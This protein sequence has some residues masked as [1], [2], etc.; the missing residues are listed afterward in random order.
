M[1]RKHEL[2]TLFMLSLF[3][4]SLLMGP[5][6]INQHDSLDSQSNMV[7]APPR[8]PYKLADSLPPNYTHVEWDQGTTSESWNDTSSWSNWEFGP[9]ITWSVSNATTGQVITLN[10]TIGINGWTNF[11]LK[12]PKNAIGGKIP[13]AVIITGTYVNFTEVAAKMSGAPYEPAPYTTS[14]LGVF[15]VSTGLWQIY[16]SKNATF[17]RGSDSGPPSGPSMEASVSPSLPPGWTL[18]DMFG[19]ELDPFL[20]INTAGCGYFPGPQNIW[21]QFQLR[22]NSSTEL[23]LYRIHALAVDSSL[24]PIAESHEDD[25][26]VRAI[27]ITF[28]QALQAVVGGYYS[29]SRVD[30]DGNILYSATRGED[31][32]TTY[33]IS[34]SYLDNATLL[35]GLPN[36]IHVQRLIES[37]YIRVVNRTGGWQYDSTLD[38]YFWNASINVRA[39]EQVWGLH[40]ETVDEWLDPTVEYQHIDPQSG[41]TVT[42]FAEL[43]IAVV[44]WFTNDSFSYL[45]H[46]EEMHFVDDSMGGHLEPTQ[47]FEPFPSDGSIPETYVLNASASGYSTDGVHDIITFR[48]H[49]SEDALPTG[50]DVAP[51]QVQTLVMDLFGRTLIPYAWMPFASTE[52]AAAYDRFRELAIDSPIAVVRL[53]H[54]NKPYD[55]SWMF[56]TQRAETFTVKSRLQGGAAYANDIDG[57]ALV[58]RG[59]EYQ[60]SDE[61]PNSWSQD[62]QVEIWMKI[63]PDGYKDVTV[64]N[65]THRVEYVY[66]DSYQWQYIETFPGHW[67]WQYIP[68]T[69]WY[70]QEFFW[71][72]EANDWTTEPLMYQSNKTVMPISYVNIGNLTYNVLG[73]D[74]SITFDVTPTVQMPEMEWQ[75]DYYYGNLTWVKD[76]EAG[77]GEHVVLDWTD[78]LVHSYEN[79]SRVYIT[80]PRR[81]VVMRDNDTDSLLDTKTMPYIV[82]G[83]EKLYV[84]RFTET[85]IDGNERQFI[86]FKEWNATA[87]NEASNQYDGDWEYYYRLTNGTRIY[88]YQGR[89]VPIYNITTPFDSFLAVENVTHPHINPVYEYMFAINGSP[90]VDFSSIWASSTNV[91]LDYIDLTKVGLASVV[92]D[93]KTLFMATYPEWVGDHYV[94]YENATWQRFDVWWGYCPEYNREAYYYVNG[95]STY[96][97]FKGIWPQDVFEGWYKGTKVLALSDTVE[98]FMYTDILGPKMWL[99]EPSKSTHDF[100]ELEHNTPSDIMVR[101]EGQ[102]VNVTYVGTYTHPTDGYNYDFYHAIVNGT[103]Y[104][105]TKFS[106]SPDTWQP[107]GDSDNPLTSIANGSLFIRNLQFNGWT[108]TYGHR[109]NVTWEF[110]P[111]GQIEVTTGSPPDEEDSGEI[112]NYGANGSQY[113]VT[114]DGFVMNYTRPDRG[115]FYNVTLSNGTFFYTAMPYPY[116]YT[117]FNE[118]RGSYDLIYW[119]TWDLNGSKVTWVDTDVSSVT[120][121]IADV[122]NST[123]E[124]FLFDGTWYNHTDYAVS[125]WNFENQ[126][127]ES[128]NYNNMVVDYDY[129]VLTN[130]TVSLEIYDLCIDKGN[131]FNMPRYN[132][133]LDGGV[134]YWNVTSSHEMI[135]KAHNVWGYPLKYDYAALPIT[136]MRDQYSLVV[137]NPEFGLWDVQSWSI[138]PATGALDLDGN[139]TTTDDQF[140]VK[141]VHESTDFYNVTEQYLQV[142]IEWEPDN[143]TVGDEFY[144]DSYTGLVTVNWSYFWADN[145][146]WYNA[147]S[148]DLLSPSE[149]N[150]YVN[151]TI[152]DPSGAPRPGYWG[153]SWMA[154]NFTSNDLK[155]KAID[156]GWD[157]AIE[158]TQEWSWVWWQLSEHYGSEMSNGT[159][160]SVDVWYE[161]A[162]MFAW[163]DTNSNDIMDFNSVDLANSEATHYWLPT[164][165]G[166]V[167]FT[168]PNGSL[169]GD[170]YWDVN[171]TVPFGVTFENVS[172]TAFPFGGNSYWDWYTGSQT[173][174]FMTFEER[175][176]QVNVT[177][178][179]IGAAFSGHINTG[180][181][182]NNGTV[183]FNL[184]VG[185]WD[186]D[187]PGGKSV[188]D[189]LSLGMAFYTDVLMVSE[190]GTILDASYFD[191]S[192]QPVSNNQ[193]VGSSNFSL[194]VG[195][196]SIA[197]MNLGGAYYSWARNKSANYTIVDS[198]TVPVDAFEAAYASQGGTTVTPF[199]ISTS[200]F[201]TLID[202]KWW[203]GYAVTVDPVFV[204]YSSANGVTDMIAPQ[205]QSMTNSTRFVDNK[206][207][208][209]V[210]VDATDTGGS[211]IREV[212]L[213]NLDDLNANTTL[214]FDSGTKQWT[215]YVEMV[216]TTPYTFNGKIEVYDYAGN[217]NSTSSF[218]HK[219]WNDPDAPSIASLGLAS[220]SGKVYAHITADVSDIGVSGIAYVEVYILNT[221]QTVRMEY[222]ATLDLYEAYVTRASNFAYTLYY[223]VRAY[224]NARNLVSSS[225]QSYRFIDAQPPVI[226]SVTGSKGEVSGDEVLIVD[227][228]IIDEGGSG[229]AS[230]QLTYTIGGHPTTVDMTY[231]SSSQLYTYTVPNQAPGTYV[232]YTVSATDNDGNTATSDEQ[233]YRFSSEGDTPP[234]MGAL[235]I[236]PTSPTSS[237]SVNVS[238][239]VLDDGTIENVTLYYRVNA[240]SWNNLSM[241]ANG[242]TYWALIP[243]QP[244]GSNVSYYVVAFDNLGQS[245]QSD[246]FYYV[247]FDDLSPPSISVSVDKAHPTSNDSVTVTAVV[248]DD[249]GIQNVTLYYKVGDGSWNMVSMTNVSASQYQG[250]IPAQSDGSVVTYY[251]RAYD[252]SGKYTDSPQLSY[253]VQDATETTTTTLPTT[254]STT[255]LPGEL[256]PMILIAIGGGVAVV[257]VIVIVLR[258]RKVK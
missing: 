3:T 236:T 35:F 19:P 233:V 234:G 212:R 87:F 230:V 224:D 147:T 195:T 136:I 228:S 114:V 197:S 170:A 41:D 49:I 152:F 52:E 145:Y 2:V 92:N 203:D 18:Q 78:S 204:S 100:Y 15:E 221:E 12:I 103:T 46:H 1:I 186:I 180:G 110:I 83:G 135:Y 258:L 142:S 250:I 25:T 37:D 79:G 63:S 27:G 23:G 223:I 102:W 211:G 227:A 158:D 39:T 80:T 66:G 216:G 14:F 29:V 214:T 139:Y 247:V 118:S 26:S 162:G 248:T 22:F 48:G 202:F 21:T 44:Y 169:S 73:N 10:D 157:W 243:A 51:L 133:T 104:N 95:S 210:S 257:V 116:D 184:T 196:D 209:Y 88:A 244:D 179:G 153:I 134:T 72:F 200:Q 128:W 61:G 252:L 105:L 160:M 32:N 113:V 127:W 57:V 38:T 75:W 181:G 140:Y 124:Q 168:T 8:M 76:Y 77:W 86:L 107:Y 91:L 201:Y 85:D 108:V 185:D 47:V 206:E 58:L 222:N 68:V 121:I 74:L 249:T 96:W 150:T 187:A 171:T 11:L 218:Q 70:W 253:T 229:L 30:D 130:G 213:V 34:G 7:S 165:F 97:F 155:Q 109:D 129:V 251:V 245:T 246:I 81:S 111:D 9:T 189:G 240:G 167:V 225:T 237:D 174:D 5:P 69:G 146:Y 176:T 99:P 161:Y 194:G 24:V 192:G 65:M 232:F 94:I 112:Q 149:F 193:T 239:T 241:T 6:P 217:M 177:E 40:W 254:T 54:Q 59:Q 242:D 71:D 123:S 143:T 256:N 156:E 178:F 208:F 231:Q 36:K 125:I 55:P 159:F 219:F 93:S 60:W 182:M 115:Y 122:Y 207:R 43:H 220:D 131:Y 138:D 13:Y 255:G 163:N 137:G 17:A 172:G 120:I 56:V 84:D 31:F 151:S 16:S 183:K 89:Q 90:V 119:Y 166:D 50:G 226:F 205:I 164:D 191:Q 45:L 198:Q 215:G 82:I 53:L 33:I 148:G 28:E 154:K 173:G 42:D 144:V 106:V 64:Y 126:F 190:T 141:S 235:S 4:L 101:L 117:L 67:E 98:Y 175:P 238:V 188:L 20:E 62:S 199:D 132:F